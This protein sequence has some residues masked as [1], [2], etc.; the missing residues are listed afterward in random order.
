MGHCTASVLQPLPDLSSWL[1]GGSTNIANEAVN[2][3]QLFS[4]QWGKTSTYT[5]YVTP[6]GRPVRWGKGLE[7][8]A[9]GICSNGV[10]DH[11]G[12]FDTYRAM[13]G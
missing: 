4:K 7:L 8:P 9:I 11:S 3:W 5:F 1:Y 13:C 12:P 6:Q 2:I 10:A